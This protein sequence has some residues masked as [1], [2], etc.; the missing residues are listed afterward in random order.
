ML[1]A[2]KKKAMEAKGGHPAL[3]IQIGGAGKDE[4]APDGDDP[5]G[6][7]PFRPHD[8]SSEHPDIPGSELEGQDPAA[9]KMASIQ[10]EEQ[11]G[12]NHMAIL[13]A[14]ADH[15]GGPSN[16]LSG[17]AAMKAKEK[18]ASMKRG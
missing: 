11:A 16:K 17:M 2:L 12:P 6:P 15:Q 3:T 18:L 7:A 8:V 5:A 10:K 9:E 13:E 4:M 14:L 1:E